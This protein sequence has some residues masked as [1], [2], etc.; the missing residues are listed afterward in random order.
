MVTIYVDF[1]LT[2]TG[3]TGAE[4]TPYT[5]DQFYTQMNTSSY[6]QDTTYLCKGTKEVLSPSLIF[7]QLPNVNYTVIMDSWNPAVNGPWRIKTTGIVARLGSDTLNSI[8]TLTSIIYKNGILD[9]DGPLTIFA[10]N[11]FANM[12]IMVTGV[13][14]IRSLVANSDVQFLGCSIVHKSDDANLRY[15]NIEDSGIGLTTLSAVHQDCVCDIFYS[16]STTWLTK[17]DNVVT[18][19]SAGS[20]SGGFLLAGTGNSILS[21]MQYDWAKPFPWPDVN[22]TRDDLQYSTKATGITLTGSQQWD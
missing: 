20:G 12:L 17:F 9:V 13:F 2:G 22:A 1:S 14:K 19:R 7:N 3:G 4:V 11:Y 6:T 18:T 8:T 15:I 16:G 5:W 10:K 21:N